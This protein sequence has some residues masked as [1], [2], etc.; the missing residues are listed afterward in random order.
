MGNSGKTDNISL[1]KI[2]EDF[3]EFFLTLETSKGI[4]F[5]IILLIKIIGTVFPVAI[6]FLTPDS[7][8]CVVSVIIYSIIIA[9]YLYIQSIHNRHLNELKKNE[10]NIYTEIVSSIYHSTANITNNKYHTLEKELFEIIQNGKTA[11]RIISNPCSQLKSI[12]EELAS[13]VASLLSN[14]SNHINKSDIYVSIIYNIPSLNDI[15]EYAESPQPSKGISAMDLINKETTAKQAF[16]SN[17]SSMVFYN[18]KALAEKNGHYYPDDD[19][20]Y[21]KGELCGSIACKKILI[22]HEGKLL[23]QAILSLS[24]YSKPFVADSDEYETDIVSYNIDESIIKGFIPRIKVELC[25]LGISI[26]GAKSRKRKVN[27]N[28]DKLKDVST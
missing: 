9:F 8:I 21:I 20:V 25:L 13:C 28:R 14:I 23:L 7:T 17:K 11:P 22:K 24:T 1:K 6:I 19:D 10:D 26:C 2:V 15:W 12:Q 16:H 3:A 27:V 4:F 18:S 5:L